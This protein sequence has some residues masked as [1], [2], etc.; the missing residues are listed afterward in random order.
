MEPNL[1]LIMRER[2]RLYESVLEAIKYLPS[3]EQANHK[4]RFVEHFD[5]LLCED[6]ALAASFL[7]V[8]GS[9]YLRKV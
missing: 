5:K 1:Q 3:N 8:D 2:F 7:S 6:A 9:R 4:Q